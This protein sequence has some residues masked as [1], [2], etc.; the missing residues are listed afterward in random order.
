MIVNGYI[1]NKEYIKALC[2]KE[3]GFTDFNTNLLLHKKKD[4]NERI[5]V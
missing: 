5:K 1:K 3:Y 2:T 4:V